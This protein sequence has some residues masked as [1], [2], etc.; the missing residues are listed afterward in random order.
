MIVDSAT[1]IEKIL[2][3]IE[4]IDKPGTEEPELVLLK[5]ANAEDVVKIIGEDMTLSSKTQPA[6]Y[7]PLKPG[8]PAT[9]VSVE[10]AKVSVL[11][12]PD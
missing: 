12:I 9:T 7:R 3:I 2:T 11:P 8:E 5:H 10:E 4:S 1:N 6:G